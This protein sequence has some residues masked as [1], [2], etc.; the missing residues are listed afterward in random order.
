M[1]PKTP[2]TPEENGVAERLNRMVISRVRAALE[3]VSLPFQTYWD[4]CALD[5]VVKM[6]STWQRTIKALPREHLN[7][8]EVSHWPFIASST[9][10]NKFRALGEYAFILRL[11]ETRNM[12]PAHC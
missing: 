2:H 9:K 6:S 10:I 11:Q 4:W 5:T 8:I 7:K 12:N 1:D 3:T